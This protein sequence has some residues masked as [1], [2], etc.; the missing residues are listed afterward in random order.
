MS[1]H[2]GCH[3]GDRLCDHYVYAGGW[4]LANGISP[5]CAD[6]KSASDSTMRC[7]EVIVSKT[8]CYDKTMAKTTL[9]ND[10][11]S[12]VFKGLIGLYSLWMGYS[13][14]AS[15]LYVH[16]LGV[17][18]WSFGK[19]STDIHVFSSPTWLVELMFYL[20]LFLGLVLFP[21]LGYCLLRSAIVQ[22]PD[23]KLDLIHDKLYQYLLL[24]LKIFI[25]V[26]LVC[27]ALTFIVGK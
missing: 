7:A 21:V 9:A 5:R 4:Q 13:Q 11:L 22:K 26:Y 16:S 17:G 6:V 2:L 10:Q 1:E 3:C 20:Q 23:K 27:I 19:Y 12:R 18:T 8:A 14:V 24:A 25:P 15:V